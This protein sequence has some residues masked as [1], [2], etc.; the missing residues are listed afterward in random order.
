MAWKPYTTILTTEEAAKI[1][2]ALSHAV[3]LSKKYP[4]YVGQYSNETI[5]EAFDLLDNH[6]RI[7][8]YETEKECAAAVM[9]AFQ[10]YQNLHGGD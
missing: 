2:M 10:D 3:S 6:E 9:K 8:G 4:D 7:G 5:Q 1:Q